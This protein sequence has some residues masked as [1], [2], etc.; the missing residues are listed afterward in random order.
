GRLPCRARLGV[1]A[2]GRRRRRAEP[3]AG[4]LGGWFRGRGHRGQ[5]ARPRHRG[6]AARGRAGTGPG[7]RR[8]PGRGHAGRRT[9]VPSYDETIAWLQRLEVSGGWDLKLER[10]RAALALRGHPEER[11]PAV[12]VAGTN[13]KGST[14]AMLESVLRASGR[15]CGLYTSPHLVDFAERIRAGGRTIPRAAVCALVAELRAA[16]ER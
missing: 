5:C 10:M 9:V 6:R 13:G 16:L 12:H 4:R 1:A 7:V 2:G 14:A 3:R 8:R 15:R 11:F